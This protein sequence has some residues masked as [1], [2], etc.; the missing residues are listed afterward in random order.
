MNKIYSHTLSLC[1]TCKS[2]IKARIIEKDSQVFMEKF[3]P[4]H[5]FSE[6]LISSD[7]EWYEQS[8]TYVKPGQI[9]QLYNQEKFSGCP[10]SCGFCV[11][12]QQHTCLPVIEISYNC[13][14][15]C[16]ICLKGECS[17]FQMT[18]AQFENILDNLIATEGTVD[19][20]NLSGGEPALHPDLNTFF[21]IAAQ[22]GISQ[23]S[24]STNGM[25]LLKNKTLRDN[26]KKY[27]VIAALQFDGFDDA[28]YTTLRGAP[29]VKEKLKLIETLE[30][31]NVLYSLV[32][33]IANN[34]NQH[35]I[36]RITDFFFQ[37][38]ALTM[39]FQP[40]TFTGAA[41]NFD[42]IKHRIT[43]ADIVREI[44]KSTFVKKG[45]FNP[46]PCSHY[47]CFA[48]AYFLKVENNQYFSLKEFLGK[49]NY[50]DVIANKTLPGLDKDGYSLMKQRLYEFWSA[51]DSSDLNDKV[52]ERI[53]KIILE[54][55]AC[56]FTQKK[57]LNMGKENMKAIFIHHFMD[58]YNFDFS[59]LVKCCNP[60]PRIDNRLVPICAQNIIFNT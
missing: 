32:V 56:G 21:E 20:V 22:I 50:L 5:G 55:N 18:P 4:D 47:S 41:S 54:M 53:R 46:L 52:I 58:V 26:L 10:D 8:L 2:K 6:T 40:L 48:L 45:D 44:E 15:N 7:K 43:I 59:R 12:H 42:H 33:T 16:P 36:S 30:N 34:I 35:E 17:N 27:G 23:L 39:M 38:K 1:N 28:T 9:P 60:Y 14:L 25:E 57:A 51:S 13:D 11:E 24:L 49:E 3:C 19:V 29:I 37:S 31:E